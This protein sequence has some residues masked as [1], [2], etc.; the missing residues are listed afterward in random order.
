[1]KKRTVHTRRG[2]MVLDI[3]RKVT[4]MAFHKYAHKQK[5][6]FLLRQHILPVYGVDVP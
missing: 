3:Q 1:M 4:V 2:S 5:L 6:Y